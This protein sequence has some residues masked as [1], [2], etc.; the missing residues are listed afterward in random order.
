MKV[1]ICERGAAGGGVWYW[2]C[3]PGAHVDIDTLTYQLCDKEDLCEDFTFK[4]HYAGWQ[5]LRRYFEFTKQKWDVMKRL[6]PTSNV[7]GATYDERGH[8]G[9]VECSDGGY[10]YGS[11]RV[12]AV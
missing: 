9:L 6:F 10:V 11:F 1:K 3:Y 2:N 8:Q 5:E 12:L 7:D 4:E